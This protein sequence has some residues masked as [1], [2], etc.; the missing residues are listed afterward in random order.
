MHDLSNTVKHATNNDD[1]KKFASLRDQPK[2]KIAHAWGRDRRGR[3]VWRFFKWARRTVLLQMHL[4]YQE[5]VLLGGY[6]YCFLCTGRWS[7]L[8]V[9][10][11]RR[12]VT[13]L[14]INK[15]LEPATTLFQQKP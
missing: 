1:T 4:I 11:N 9:T 14:E 6:R 12:V 13:N 7:L 15:G 3:D 8:A 10:R 5:I 2:R